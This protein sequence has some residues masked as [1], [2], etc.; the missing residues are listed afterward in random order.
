VQTVGVIGLGLMG[1]ALC[2]RFLRAGM[3]VVGYD[4][5]AAA[6]RSLV[7]A[8]GREAVSTEALIRSA[9]V[10]VLSLP[11]ASIVASVLA[12]AADA[13]QPGQLLIDTTTGAPWQVEATAARLAERGIGYLDATVAGSSAQVLEGDV[14]VMVGGTAEAYHQAEPLLGTFA[15]RSFHVGGRGSGS[16]M[17]L[18]VNLVLGLHR[19][20][21]AE[22]L[23]LA[24]AIELDPRATLD[25][26]RSSAAY[27]AVMDTKGSKMLAEDFSPQARLSQH[28]KDVRLILA[29]GERTAAPLPLSLLH[30]SLLERVE[31]AGHGELDN[32]AVLLAF[33]DPVEPRS[34]TP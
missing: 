5:A 15:R 31:A 13:L 10:I 23:T 19:A 20:V 3:A 14:I 29:A 21:L 8:G 11:D 18:V 2:A 9:D 30:R 34:T 26:L 4:L 12:S 6:R 27:S 28:L 33:R 32:C 22:A 1:S 16:R 7:A 17:K 24:R 25:V